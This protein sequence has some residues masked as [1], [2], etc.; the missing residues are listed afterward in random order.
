VGSPSADSPV[1]SA[2]RAHAPDPQTADAPTSPSTASTFAARARDANAAASAAPRSTRA[3]RATGGS[4]SAPR[5]R[6]DRP[7]QPR[8]VVAADGEQQA[9]AATREVRRPWQ[10]YCAGAWQ[11]A[12]APPRT[13][14]KRERKEHPP[15]LADSRLPSPKAWNR[16][17]ETPQG[18][19]TTPPAVTS[20]LRAG[21]ARLR[22]TQAWSTPALHALQAR[23]QAKSVPG[24]GVS[25]STLTMTR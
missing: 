20:C 21:S 15:M 7:A 3:G 25:I 4:A 14:R 5:G 12:A 1:P 9:D 16:G 11:A 23:R 18:R 22:T 2:A 19:A 13:P 10:T 24:P 17:F 6:H 8:S